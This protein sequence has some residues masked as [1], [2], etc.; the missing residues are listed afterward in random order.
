MG[1]QCEL[2]EPVGPCGPGVRLIV[3]VRRSKSG[4][5]L[6]VGICQTGVGQGAGQ[7]GGTLKWVCV[8]GSSLPL[9]AICAPL[10]TTD[11]CIEIDGAVIASPGPSGASHWVCGPF[12]QGEVRI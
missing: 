4:V 10:F 12:C 1:V 5:P 2:C 8:K 7:V 9:Q 11:P 3:G 6:S